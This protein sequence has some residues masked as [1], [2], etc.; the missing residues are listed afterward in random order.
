MKCMI[1]NSISIVYSLARH[2]DSQNVVKRSFDDESQSEVIDDEV[3]QTDNAWEQ[4]EIH[5]DM[6]VS[7][8]EDDELN[9]DFIADVSEIKTDGNEPILPPFEERFVSS[10]IFSLAHR[11]V[12]A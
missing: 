6:D 9:Q 12:D 7:S 10:Q 4:D 8:D 11:S 5:V 2:A 1:F 3:M